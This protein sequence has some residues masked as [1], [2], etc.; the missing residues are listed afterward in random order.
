MA[1]L[2]GTTGDGTTLPVLVDQFGNL[3]A[4]GI[5]GDEGPPGPPGGAFALPPDPVDGDVLGWE[6]G[7]LAWVPLIPLPDGT[8]GPYVYISANESLDIP[9]DASGLANGLE[10]FMSDSLGNLVSPIFDTDT[11]SNV[12]GGVLTFPT[13]NNFD[14]F[15][16]GDVVQVTGVTY[17]T[18]VGPVVIQGDPFPSPGRISCLPNPSGGTPGTITFTY[19]QP[20]AFTSI[21][22]FSGGDYSAGGIY[23][24][25][26][27]D[28]QGVTT[29]AQGTTASGYS[30]TALPLTPPSL[31]KSFTITGADGYA[32]LGFYNGSTFVS[33]GVLG[34]EVTITAPPDVANKTITVSG[35]SWY[36]SDGSGSV[37]GDTFL[38]KQLSGSG[39]VLLGS[40]GAIELDQN[41]SEWVNGYYVTSIDNS[42]TSNK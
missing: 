9:Q 38:S 36:G 16:V 23:T 42:I 30:V 41:N 25:S 35:G 19:P 11:I 5:P 32:F 29:S 27:T 20:V 2:F 39:S 14:K 15:E 6:N 4:K 18:D 34:T 12:A 21:N 13:D 1:I 28:D 31:V 26:F 17:V 3:L 10:L 22:N 7:Q 37:G 8:F 24:F 40:E 33:T